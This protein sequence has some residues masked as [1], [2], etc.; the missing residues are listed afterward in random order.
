MHFLPVVNET[1]FTLGFIFRE[2]AQVQAVNQCHA[3]GIGS[4]S[5]NKAG[6]SFD[7]RRPRL[8]SLQ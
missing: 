1:S 5:D 4:T 7:V 3:Y 6:D 2:F 8:C